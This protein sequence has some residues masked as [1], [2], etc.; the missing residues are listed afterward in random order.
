MRFTETVYRPPQEA[1]SLLLRATQGCTYNR[2]NFCYISRG[3]PFMSNPVAGLEREVLEK[4][5]QPGLTKHIY[6][7]GSNPFA[8]PF[9][10]LAA[11]AAVI[12]GHIPDFAEIS[13]QAMVRDVAAKTDEELRRLCGLGIRHLYIGTENGNDAALALMNKGHTSKEALTQLWRLDAAGIAYTTQYILGMAGSGQGR[14]SAAATA[15]FFNQV[16][17]RRIT[18]T[19]LT[20]FPGAPLAR[21]LADGTF[22][23]ASEKEKVEE[24]L[25]F[26]ERLTTDTL[27]DSM[28]Y[29]N[30]LNYRFASKDEKEAV[31]ADIKEALTEYS[32]EDFTLIAGREALASL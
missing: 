21:M 13:T 16:H 6:L 19:G 26:L 20:V 12:S 31:V 30:A 23:Q 4:K 7:V 15:A 29:L 2:C 11:Y 1:K 24:M 22:V 28:H 18:T 10:T 32:A 8:L 25:A 3:N 9:E 5:E 27:F 14:R 17:P